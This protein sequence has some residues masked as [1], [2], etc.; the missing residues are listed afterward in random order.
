MVAAIFAWVSAPKGISK[1]KKGR[2]N[3]RI[4]ALTRYERLGS[5]SR[6]RFYQ[7]IPYLSKKGVEIQQA[8]FFSDEY[9][10]RLYSGQPVDIVSVGTAYIKRVLWALRS[11]TFNLLWIEK[12]ILPWMPHWVEYFVSQGIPSVVDYDDAVFHRYEYHQNQIVRKLLGGKIDRVMRSSSL[13]IAGNNYLAERARQSGSEW[14]E[15][16]PSVV[17]VEKYPIKETKPGLNIGWIGSPA[18]VSF[19]SP[20]EIPL[21]KLMDH[22]QTVQLTLIGAGKKDP[23]PGIR[24][25]ILPWN[26]ETE[27]MDLQAF[28]VGIMPLPDGPFERGKC[29]YKLVQYMAGGLPVIASPIGVNEKIVEHGVNGYLASTDGEWLDAFD[30]LKNNI[31]KRRQMGLAGRNKAEENYN[32]RVTA[33]RLL[34]L[35]QSVAG[36][37]S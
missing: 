16:L 24:K 12:E 31:D 6:V 10:R 33:P 4:L 5:S 13:V 34:E 26:E 18:T 14:V 1:L 20:L 22:S 28:D 2:I 37:N 9:I 17:D 29:G 7:Y 35:F 23:L 36:Q 15:I 27:M 30:Q 32:L 19:L 25:I 3:L 8:P 21:K 11:R